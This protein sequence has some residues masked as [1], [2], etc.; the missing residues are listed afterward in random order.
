MI[1][2]FLRKELTGS[3]LDTGIEHHLLGVWGLTPNN[4]FS[5]IYE[6]LLHVRFFE[7]FLSERKYLRGKI[8]P[9]EGVNL[10]VKLLWV[11]SNT[12]NTYWGY[13]GLPPLSVC[14]F[15][16]EVS[17]IISFWGNYN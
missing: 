12:T 3:V 1:L 16:K 14:F 5:A 10:T 17:V 6:L 9:L 8:L 4:W 15:T 2:F 11:T 7:Y 13:G